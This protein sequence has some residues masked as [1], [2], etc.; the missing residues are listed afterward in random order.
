MP[1]DALGWSLERL[2]FDV[3][4]EAYKRRQKHC[5]GKTFTLSGELTAKLPKLDEARLEV[6]RDFG[7]GKDK[8]L[9][10]EFFKEAFAITCQ[11]IVLKKVRISVLTLEFIL[12]FVVG[13]KAGRL[14][15]IPSLA[16]IV[17]I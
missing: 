14:Q 17:A 15:H 12:F 4:S 3:E 8:S 9:P 6:L 7:N 5:G 16:S 13:E 10:F 2:P 11:D 1:E